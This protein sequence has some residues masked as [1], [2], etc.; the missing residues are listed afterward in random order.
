M[1]EQQHAARL[2]Q[3]DKEL[4]ELLHDIRLKADRIEQTAPGSL[5][6][7]DLE[8]YARRLRSTRDYLRELE[9]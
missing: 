8:A 3:V 1:T 4:T 9:P 2:A 5:H 7:F 6:A